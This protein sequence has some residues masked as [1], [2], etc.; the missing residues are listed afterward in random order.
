MDVARLLL[1][2]LVGF[3]TVSKRSNL[4]AIDYIE[5]W[6]DEHGVPSRRTYDAD[7]RKANLFATIGSTEQAG[8]VVLSGHTDVV[9]VLDQAWDTEPFRVV[10]RDGRLY[11]R[12]TADMKSFI[13]IALAAVPEM[14]QRRLARPIHLAFTYDEEVGCLGV[15]GLIADVIANLPRPGMVIVGEPS[16]MRIV[17]AHKGCRVYRTCV[18]GR[19][20]H[21]SRPQDGANALVAASRIAAFL[22]DLQDELAAAAAPGSRFDPPHTTIGIGRIEGGTAANVIP[23]RASLLWDLREVPDEDVEALLA[24]VDGF[25]AERV[26][27]ELRR[28]VPESSV[29]TEA[30]ARVP[31]MAPEP[32]GAADALVRGL[33]GDNESG[34]VSFCTEGGLFQ[35]AGLS[36]VICGPGN[37]E[38]AHQPNEFIE[39]EQVSAGIGFVDRLVD[40]LS[41][42]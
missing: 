10:E 2:D 4:A 36:C 24:R 29:E 9:P 16:S 34:A 40:R 3:D 22:A 1:D 14:T 19:S 8:G 38:Q 20:A 33:T 17:D 11:G 31:P 28:T 26:L 27:P 15:G 32:D 18:T 30:L 13:A 12:G 6:L 23:E 7:Q 21:S 5:A 42:R 35:E 25:V 37:I 41:V 39:L